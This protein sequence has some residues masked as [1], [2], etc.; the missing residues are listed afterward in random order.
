[1]YCLR[2]F[3]IEVCP[4]NDIYSLGRSGDLLYSCNLKKASRRYGSHKASEDEREWPNCVGPDN[5][6]DAY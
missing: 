1:M 2:K 3:V 5:D 6:Y 4:P